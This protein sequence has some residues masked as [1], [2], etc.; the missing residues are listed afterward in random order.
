MAMQGVFDL[1]NII[2]DD[3]ERRAVLRSELDA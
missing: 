1:R 3:P 2:V